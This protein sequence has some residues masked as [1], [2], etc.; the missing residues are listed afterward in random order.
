MK[1]FRS[2]SFAPIKKRIGWFCV[3]LLVATFCVCLFFIAIQDI[4]IFPGVLSG[5]V[6]QNSGARRQIP[7]GVVG[8]FVTTEDKTKIEVWE[9]QLPEPKEPKQVAI[10]FHGN[11]ADVANF[12]PYQKWLQHQ[13]I[14]SYGFDYR[15]YGMSEGWPS[16]K[17]LFQDS[18]AVVHFV[19]KREHIAPSNLIMFGVSIGSGFAARAAAL[20]NARMLVMIPP[21]TSVTDLAKETPL[22]GVLWPFLKYHIP[23]ND[24]I[25]SLYNTCIIA[26]HGRRDT[27]IPPAHS[28]RLFGSNRNQSKFKMLF[29]DNAGHN[30]VFFKA[31]EA[32]ARAMEECRP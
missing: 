6:R 26:M 20:T 8:H 31:P 2:Q 24:F 7:S 16:E 28:D 27:I 5:I 4:L 29:I 30:D 22:F 12:F 32:L 10:V 21:Y 3:R 11:G 14:V 1:K 18:D 13:G 9:L 15:G 25:S 23:T 19:A 17:G